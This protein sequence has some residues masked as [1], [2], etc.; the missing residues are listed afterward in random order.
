MIEPTGAL[1]EFENQINIAVVFPDSTLPTP[2]NWG[3]QNQE[4]FRKYVLEHQNGKWQTEMTARATTE[5]EQDYDDNTIGDT[6]PLQFPFGHTGLRM[7]P[8][9][10][11]CHTIERTDRQGYPN[12]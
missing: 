3:F 11:M 6:F 12:C 9:G 1:P 10:S 5:R 2:T 8:V 7:D 4:E